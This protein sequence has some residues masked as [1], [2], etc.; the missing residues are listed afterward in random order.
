MASIFISYARDDDVRP[1]KTLGEPDL[2]GFVTFLDEQLRYQFRELGPER[3]QIWRDTKRISDGAQFTPEIE[4]ALRKASLFL[5]VLSPNW[6]ASPWCRKELATFAKYHGPD[7]IHER[8]VVVGKR[9]VD[10]DKRPSL[11]Q[12]Q[13]GFRF[14]T[15]SEDPD[16]IV[17]G[18]EFFGRGKVQD[19]RYW[20][21]F[22]ALVN[23]LARRQIV[24]PFLD[25]PPQGRTFYVAKPASDMRAGYDRIVSEL[26]KEGH[27]VVPSPSEEIPLE[28]AVSCI[29]AALSVAEFS[30]HVLGEK[31]GPA[32][33]DQLPLVKLQLAR[34]TERV[35]TAKVGFHRIIWAPSSWPGGLE[36][37]VT[38]RQPGDVLAKFDDQSKNNGDK[39]QG[40]SLNAFIGYLKQH[41]EN[42]PPSPI[43][44]G[45]GPGRPEP[46][47]AIGGA[48]I[49]LYHSE[50]DTDY[51]LRL[52]GVLQQ[53]SLETTL[54][55][56]DGP[57]VATNNLNNK[58]L[59]ECDAVI[60]CWASA[61][62]VWVQAEASKLR[63]WDKLGRTRKFAY[64][65]VVT[66]PPPGVRKRNSNVLF[67]RSEV[68]LVVDWSEQ[69]FPTAEQVDA[70]IPNAPADLQ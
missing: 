1:P 32:P 10:P 61:S 43:D 6:M 28:S 51:A 68:D 5:A 9:H 7:G 8:I 39:V 19:H 18:V 54:P 65:A 49:Y 23:H 59:A 27:T 21:K 40:E 30:I 41:I 25:P 44:E 20:D 55:V 16:E 22:G 37:S 46:P 3:P 15:L 34:A 24:K 33:E 56:F 52:A 42:V 53:R 69:G 58:R 66:A 50:Q 2:K 57:E 26:V 14:Y 48:R 64:R 17:G 12:G 11:M 31:V 47:D 62:E 67:P 35:K 38:S 29:D 63:S 36:T 60:L 4:D 45:A 13:V 70:L